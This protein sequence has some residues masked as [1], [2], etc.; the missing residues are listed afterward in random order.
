V[1][2]DR[3]QDKAFAP[4]RYVTELVARDTVNTMPGATLKA[5]GDLGE[6]TPDTI[7]GRY[8]E[9][10][11]AVDEL[12]TLGINLTD[13]A[14]VLEREGL[15]SFVKSWDD[16]IASVENQLKSAGAEVMPAGAVKPASGDDASTT[17]PAAAA[18]VTADKEEHA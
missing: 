17:A 9:A 13:V 3:G 8:A 15:A 12:A 1:G 10:R 18:P 7:T 6:A 2:V 5:V 14:D 16:L 11:A 4:T